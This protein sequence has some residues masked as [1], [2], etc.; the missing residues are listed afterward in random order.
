[1]LF[2][3]FTP[4]T[5]ADGEGPAK[6][7]KDAKVLG[8]EKPVD[9]EPAARV[10]KD[11]KVVEARTETLA[12]LATLAAP[13]PSTDIE[14][15][16]DPALIAAAIEAARRTPALDGIAF[17]RFARIAVEVNH[18]LAE[19]LP[20]R[21]TEAAALASR[22]WA[23]AAELIRRFHYYDCYNLLEELPGKIRKFLPQ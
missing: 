22:T 14:N 16:L 6:V 15:C 5:S 10:A 17:E 18:A 13:S 19:V 8:P 20:S 4:K 21:R 9:R 12:T 1:V 23:A 11:A 7:A 2:P 3:K